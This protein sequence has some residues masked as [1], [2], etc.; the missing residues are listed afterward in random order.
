MKRL[1][2]IGRGFGGLLVVGLAIAG[3]V[4]TALSPDIALPLLVLLMP[5]LLL[6]VLDR[7]AGCGIA[8]AVLLF[9]V[10]AAVHPVA[11]AWY[12]C[13]GVK[14]CMSELGA[15]HRVLAVWLAG[16]AGWLLTQLLPLGLK[17]VQD[18]RLEARK[19][20]LSARRAVLV[21]EW[22]LEDGG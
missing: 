16:A 8:R 14:G 7:S 17:L 19:S 20:E 3:G 1:K 9:Q 21:E 12:G 11:G 10:A 4:L 13:S 18:Q 6:L 2:G 5:G 15:W 22:G